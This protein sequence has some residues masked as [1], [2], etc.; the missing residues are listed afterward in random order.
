MAAGHNNGF[1]PFRDAHGK[2]SLAGAAN[3]AV[4]AAALPRKGSGAMNDSLR[5]MGGRAIGGGAYSAATLQAVMAQPPK[6]LRAL[7]PATTANL[8]DMLQTN[9]WQAAH[10]TLNGAAFSVLSQHGARAPQEEVDTLIQAYKE[11]GFAPPAG[12]SNAELLGLMDHFANVREGSAAESNLAA[13]GIAAALK[14]GN[15]GAALTFADGPTGAGIGWDLTRQELL[16][17]LA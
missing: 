16:G 2:F 17:N 9:D 15:Q 8:N 12:A 13:Y 14:A 5:S 7:H 6:P 3:A 10:D 11:T 4:S 1:N